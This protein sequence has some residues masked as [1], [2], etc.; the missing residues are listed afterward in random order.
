MSDPSSFLSVDTCQ[1]AT[2]VPSGR[3]ST[4]GGSAAVSIQLAPDETVVGRLHPVA[5]FSANFRL[6]DSPLRSTQLRR[7]PRPETVKRG[8]LLWV[9]DGA[10][11][12]S[13]LTAHAGAAALCGG[14]AASAAIVCPCAAA[15][16]RATMETMVSVTRMCCPKR[17]RLPVQDRR[18]F[19]W[20]SM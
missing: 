10:G 15:R 3:R 13:S 1:V 6:V 7:T 5:C 4:I 8:P 9:P 19:E 11:S 17:G 14:A 2:S 12:G 18:V 16:E 20:Y